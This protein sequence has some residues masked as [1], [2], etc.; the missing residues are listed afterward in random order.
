[1]SLKN[2]YLY[3]IC[4]LLSFQ[5]ISAQEIASIEHKVRPDETLYSLLKLYKCT[6]DQFYMLNPSLKGSNTIY[7]NQVILFPTYKP[8]NTGQDVKN[9]T[10]RTEKHRVHVVELNE[11]AYSISRKYGVT[12][13]DLA[14][15]N[16]LEAFQI[17][18]GQK[19]IIKNGGEFD[20]NTIGQIPN[21]KP[22]EVVVPNAPTGEQVV[23]LGIAEVIP[24]SRQSTKFLA[25]HKTAPVGSLISVRNEATGDQV[26]VKVI[27]KLPN[28]GNNENILIRLSEAA[29]Q[30]LNPKDV[31]CRARVVYYLPPSS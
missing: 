11:T 14:Q 12:P 21:E 26:V 15:W 7:V 4:L 19:L 30:K 13:T 27:G 24:T 25:L 5:T 22:V 29:Y 9:V 10:D 16:N 28:T 20:E 8:S 31:K 17:K 18:V 3:F 6:P 2:L 1:M 23:E